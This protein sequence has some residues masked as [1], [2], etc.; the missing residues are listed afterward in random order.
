MLAAQK[1]QLTHLY[2]RAVASHL[3]LELKELENI[4]WLGRDDLSALLRV[5]PDY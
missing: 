5:K 2:Y 3:E 1:S 4:S